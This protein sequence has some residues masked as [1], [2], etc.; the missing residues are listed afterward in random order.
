MQ[1]PL[2]LIIKSR[3]GPILY[4]PLPFLGDLTIKCSSTSDI[5]QIFEGLILVKILEK[6][7]AAVKFISVFNA[8]FL[9]S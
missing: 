2:S 9:N 7:P 4:H 1:P 3:I 8:V 6:K 5:Q